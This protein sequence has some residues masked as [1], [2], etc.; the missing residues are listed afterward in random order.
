MEK[1]IIDTQSIGNIMFKLYYGVDKNTI[2][3]NNVP[4]DGYSRNMEVSWVAYT[5]CNYG[6]MLWDV[7]VN[8]SSL[9]EIGEKLISFSEKLSGSLDK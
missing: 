2:Y 8:A 3:N 6:T 1:L 4:V 5:G 9:K 7:P